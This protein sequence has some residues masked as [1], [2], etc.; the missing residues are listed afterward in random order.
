VL[1]DTGRTIASSARC[2]AL[3][4]VLSACDGCSRLLHEIIEEATVGEWRLGVSVDPET[5]T[6]RTAT[7]SLSA[8]LIREVLPGGICQYT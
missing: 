1:I 8:W 4:I 5:C 2:N 6:E 7:Q 3:A